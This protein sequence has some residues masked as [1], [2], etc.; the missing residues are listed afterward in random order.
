MITSRTLSLSTVHVNTTGIM[1]PT[2]PNRSSESLSLS[3]KVVV[4]I[5]HEDDGTV[6]VNLACCLFGID[7]LSLTSIWADLMVCSLHKK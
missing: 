7:R 1:L 6:P 4:T 2:K 3:V 5:F